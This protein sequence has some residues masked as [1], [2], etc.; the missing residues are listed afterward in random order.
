MTCPKEIDEV[1]Y[2][3][4]DELSYDQVMQSAKTR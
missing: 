2:V 1:E 3:T 4:Y